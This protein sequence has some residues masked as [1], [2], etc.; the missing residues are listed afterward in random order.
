M[1]EKRLNIKHAWKRRQVNYQPECDVKK[2][3]QSLAWKK[4]RLNEKQDLLRQKPSVCIN[5][6][7]KR[8]LDSR[9]LLLKSRHA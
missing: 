4:R 8:Q 6:S 2:T 3:V 1:L 7:K 5:C 9:E